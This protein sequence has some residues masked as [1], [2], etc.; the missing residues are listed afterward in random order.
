MPVLA[1]P[2]LCH[3]C[4]LL[5]DDHARQVRLLSSCD[6]LLQ[7]IAHIHRHFNPLASL[8]SLAVLCSLPPEGASLEQA[9][10]LQE[11]DCIS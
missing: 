11:Y 6:V 9:K 1:P 5:G 3:S 8:Y 7:I 10:A 2:R 4:R